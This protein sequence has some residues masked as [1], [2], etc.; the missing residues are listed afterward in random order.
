M[1]NMSDKELD[2]LF[3][4]AAEGFTPPQDEAAW[5]QMA[6]RLDQHAVGTTSFWNWKT[7]SAVTATAVIS[8]MSVWFV[9]GDQ[10]KISKT[11]EKN[12]SNNATQGVVQEQKEQAHPI[13][14]QNLTA[15]QSLED[16]NDGA[17]AVDQTERKPDK[18]QVTKD[19]QIAANSSKTAIAPQSS[20]K[21]SDKREIANSNQVNNQATNNNQVASNNNKTTITQQS[22]GK[23]ND[24]IQIT[25]L[26]AIAITKSSGNGSSNGITPTN[27][28][29]GESSKR[30]ETVMPMA[31]ESTRE[32]AVSKS[33]SAPQV[34]A[35]DKLLIAGD[36]VKPVTKQDTLVD[37]DEKITD[38]PDKKDTKTKARGVVS[39]K[40]VVSPDYSSIN[41]FSAGETGFNYGLLA[42]YSFNNRWSV[43]TGIIS[44]KKL[45]D[46][47]EIE[48]S[49]NSNGH[50]YPVKELNG[51]C[52][53]L[54]IPINVYYTF[55]PERS[56][57]LR[58]GLGFSSYIMREETYVFCVDNYGTD[59]Y[60]AKQVS[61]ENN[62]WFKILNLSV[63]VSKKISNRWSAE[64]EP[65]V[66][67]PLAGVG[68]GKVSLVSM[69]AF[70]NLKFDLINL[71]K[72]K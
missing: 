25:N 64:F 55:F 43:Y 23:E 35:N 8:I 36:S 52:R 6:D 68:E 40:A 9:A 2:N 70:I 67:A 33:P 5:K 34:T 66:K 27:D 22:L 15:A 10:D 17:H 21:E 63:A 30:S 71:T 61:G 20:G 12:E 47:K 65:F 49:Y 51:D 50:D 37:S 46:T 3:K 62:E 16:E 57:S 48:G 60:Y 11:Q 29:V 44:S 28:Q 26:S 41:F 38:T 32:V 56:F 18:S 72:N 19:S 54:D 59:A 42:G 7:I 45:Y 69:G 53:I 31:D 58:V 39:I 1:Q 4:E 14:K 13:G 24:K